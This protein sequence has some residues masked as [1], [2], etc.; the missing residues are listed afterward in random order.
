MQVQVRRE[1]LDRWVEL[2]EETAQAAESIR[3]II[4]TLLVKCKYRYAG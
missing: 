3:R 4:V 1:G 2:E